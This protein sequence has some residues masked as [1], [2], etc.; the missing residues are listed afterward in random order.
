MTLLIVGLIVFLGIH[1]VRIVAPSW[2]EARIAVMGENKW[3]G[4]YSIIS[5]VSFAMLVFGYYLA[6]Q[7]AGELYAPFV[8]LYHP[9]LLAMM[10]SMIALMVFNIGP[11]HLKNNL[12]H[13]FLVSI[14]LWSCAHLLMN[15]DTASVLLFGAFL[16]WSV[17]DLFSALSRPAQAL[18]TPQ[19]RN[20]VIAVVSGLIIFL[21]FYWKL[22][23][24][25]MGVVPII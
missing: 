15:G 8:S 20:D 21:L 11:G 23:E 24:W 17:I 1:S 19:S 14:I 12:R 18:P 13:P 25:L 2:R 6:R 4:V 22:H 10:L 16:A 5:L 3:K 7:D 9:V